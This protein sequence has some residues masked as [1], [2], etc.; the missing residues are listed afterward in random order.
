[1]PNLLQSVFF[2]SSKP[3]SQ[4]EDQL[5]TR[6]QCS[7]ECANASSHSIVIDTPIGERCPLVGHEVLQ[8]LLGPG[9]VRLERDGFSREPVQGLERIGIGP[10]GWRQFCGG[11]ISSQFPSQFRTNALTSLESVVNMRRQS[12]GSGM[13]LDRPDQCLADPPNRV[14]GELEAPAMVEFLHRSNQPQITFLN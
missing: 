13:V 5:L 7:N 10:K 9:D 12:N 6:G 8:P 11:R 4:A 3:V 14:S 2:F 1:M